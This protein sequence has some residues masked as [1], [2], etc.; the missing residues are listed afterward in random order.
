MAR[1]IRAVA[2]LV[3]MGNPEWAAIVLR[4]LHGAGHEFAAV[5]TAPDKPA[6]RGR[7]LAPPPVKA[8]ARELG[9]PVEQPASLKNPEAQARLRALS[10]D[11]IVVV[12]YGLLLP[13]AVLDIP[14]GGCLNLHYS[15]L[16]KWRGAAPVQRCLMAGER[17]T[18]AAVMRMDA[19]LDTGPLVLVER[20]AIG[21]D[22]TADELGRRLSAIG[23]PLLDRA[24][25]GL[26]SGA[27]TPV[28][29]SGEPTRA[30]KL[31][32]QEARLDWSLPA[33]AVHARVRG[34]ALWPVAEHEIAGK[35]VKLLKTGIANLLPAA[36]P[37]ET[38]LRDGH[39]FIGCGDGLALELLMVKPEGKGAMRGEDFARGLRL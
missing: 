8:L 35:R 1:I 32:K 3:F 20:V 18:G 13:P 29:Q 14:R 15:L 10:P 16:P 2:R 21:A 4:S 22:E 37:G 33:A 12:A 23:G 30:K 6:G 28:P 31:T 38:V 17:E 9:L 19:G 27:L 24:I 36:N 5:F 34:L 7:T 11:F 26:E 25:R 39:L